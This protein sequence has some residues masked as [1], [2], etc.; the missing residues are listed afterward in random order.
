MSKPEKKVT[1]YYLRY[2][3]DPQH[4]NIATDYI[5]SASPK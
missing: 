1:M 4:L 3:F 5:H 2:D